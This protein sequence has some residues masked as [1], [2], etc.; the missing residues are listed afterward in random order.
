M[1][2][3]IRLNFKVIIYAVIALAM[4]ALVILTFLPG[5][6][7]AWKDSGKSVNDKCQTPPGYTQESWREHMGHHP[8]IY[9]ECL[10]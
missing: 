2:K 7:Q 4:V 9:K 6:I 5:I 8:D 3:T 10:G 1:S